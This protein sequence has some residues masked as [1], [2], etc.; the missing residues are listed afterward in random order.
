MEK[1][2]VAGYDYSFWYGMF[3]PTGTPRAVVNR[4]FDAT[5]QALKDPRLKQILA[6]DGTE[7]APSR[8]PEDFVAWLREEGKLWAKLVKESGAKV[9]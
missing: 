3:A 7:T 5:V 6:N 9:D 1:A 4:L 2:G 8:S